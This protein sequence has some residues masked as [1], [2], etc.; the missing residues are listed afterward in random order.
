MKT[1]ITSVCI[2]LATVALAEGGKEAQSSFGK[3][4]LKV[5]EVSTTNALDVARAMPENLYDFKPNDSSKTFAEQMVHIA[6]STEGLAKGFILGEKGSGNQQE[7]ASMSKSDIISLMEKSFNTATN[8]ISSMTEEQ[9]NETIKVFGG[10]EVTR[11]IAVIFIQDHL[12]NHRAK[13][14]LYIRMNDI[15]PP[16][17]GFF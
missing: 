17:Y 7:V 15:T 2:L 5:W 3:N 10:K 1:V 9:A 14:N 12:A 6:T 16:K 4:F 8:A 11:Y 13:A